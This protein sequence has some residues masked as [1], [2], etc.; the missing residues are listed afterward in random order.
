MAADTDTTK[1]PDK[2]APEQRA[3]AENEPVYSE[4]VS[5]DRGEPRRFVSVTFPLPDAEGKP[6]E[7]CTIATDVTE[8]RE[9]ESERRERLRMTNQIAAALDEDRL[10]AYAQ[11][12]VDLNTDETHAWELLARLRTTGVRQA[13]LGP[14]SFLPDAERFELVQAIDTSIVRQ[15]LTLKSAGRLHVNISAVT[16]SDPVGR[17]AVIELLEEN[18]ETASQ[19][20]FEVTETASV[21]HLDA[22]RAFARAAVEAGATL[23]LD[24]FGVGFGAFTYLRSLPVSLI[25]IDSTFVRRMVASP[26]DWRVV[27]G[28]LGVAREFGVRTVAEGIENVATLEHLRE[29]G[30]DF[31]QGHLLGRPSPLLPGVPSNH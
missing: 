7:L 25:K 2:T 16:I 12:I 10:I 11:P 4:F 29:L 15:A 13:I 26:E 30:V 20:V 22:A 27:K 31:G 9:K 18:P 28:V 17:S 14:E 21:E 24:D 3:A 8:R 6:A 5:A 23:A 1:G 19:L